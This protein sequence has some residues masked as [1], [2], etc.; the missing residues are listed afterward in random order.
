[1]VSTPTNSHGDIFVRDLAGGTTTLVSVNSS[2][3]AGG[4]DTSDEPDISDDGNIIA[5]RSFATD[6]IGGFVDGNGVS[7]DVFARDRTTNNT[8]LVSVNSGNGSTGG[9]ND[10]SVPVVSGDGSRVVFQSLA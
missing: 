2:G 3:S 7:A 10:S 8:S 4:N 1:L 9:N 5:Y 6:L